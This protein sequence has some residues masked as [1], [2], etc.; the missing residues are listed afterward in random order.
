MSS[1][2][3]A[4]SGQHGTLLGRPDRRSHGSSYPARA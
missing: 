1:A 2:L 3:A 4:A